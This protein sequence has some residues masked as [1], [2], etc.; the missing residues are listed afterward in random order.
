MI[1]IPRFRAA[2]ALS[3]GLA[4]STPMTTAAQTPRDRLLVSTGWVAEHRSDPHLVILH[5]GEKGGYDR[6]H[7]P[8]ARFVRMQDVAAPHDMHDEASLA[9]QMPEPRAL[10]AKLQE[11]GIS[12]DSR[13]VVYYG[14]DW[15]SPSTRVV[16]TLNWAGLGARTVLMDGGLDAWQ[17]EHRPVTNAVPAPAAGRLSALHPAADL[18]VDAEWVKAHIGASG[19]AIVD[20]RA[21]AFYDGVQKTR[22]RAGHIPGAHSIPFTELTDDHDRVRSQAELAEVFRAAGVRPGDTVVGYCHIGQQA[23]AMLFAAR[24]LGYDVKLYDGSFQDWDRRTDL[25]VETPSAGGTR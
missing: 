18:V 3:A 10:R 22:N 5:V 8:G 16:Y 21:R 23:T 15:V 11:W 13:I 4:L 7:L 24:L 9:L 12:D 2:L 19:V 14:G 20:G 17:A 1:P 25:P 6:A